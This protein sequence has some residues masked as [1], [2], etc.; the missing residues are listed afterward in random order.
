M[1]SF[2]QPLR[3]HQI[4]FHLHYTAWLPVYWSRWYLL[5]ITY[6]DLIKDKH[7]GGP[8]QFLSTLSFI[9]TPAVVPQQQHLSTHKRSRF[10][11]T[12][13][14]NSPSFTLITAP[15]IMCVCVCVSVWCQGTVTLT[16]HQ[17]DSVSSTL[18]QGQL[19]PLQSLTCSHLSSST[20]LSISLCLPV[21]T[22]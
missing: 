12:V 9:P 16:R 22:L 1:I 11:L 3:R 7:P 18:S 5:Y 19:L 14:I 15:I 17:A 6:C 2:W 10:F 8:G 13:T 20:S 4:W 21:L